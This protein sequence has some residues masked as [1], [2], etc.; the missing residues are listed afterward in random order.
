MSAFPKPSGPDVHPVNPRHPV[1]RAVAAGALAAALGLAA[2]TPAPAPDGTPS[3]SS[4]VPTSTA[5]AGSA[6][7]CPAL[8]ATVPS[9]SPRGGTI[10]PSA[11]DAPALVRSDGGTSAVADADISR[12]GGSPAAS[13]PAAGAASGAAVE[14]TGGSRLSLQRST[15]ASSGNGTGGVSSSGT[16]SLVELTDVTVSTDG[17]SAAG[18]AAGDGGAVTGTNLTVSTSQ[19]GANALAAVGAGAQISLNRS[20]ASATGNLSA[21]VYSAGDVSVCGLAGTSRSSEAALVEGANTLTS[22]RSTLEGGTNGAR[23]YQGDSGGPAGGSLAVSGGSLTGRTGDAVLI[24][25]VPATVTLSDGAGLS[26]GSGRLV[27]VTA[28]GS[29]TVNVTGTQLRGN[30]TAE[31]GSGLDLSLASNSSVSGT[32]TNVS[33]TLD[34]TSTVS[35]ESDSTAASVAGAEVSGNEILN[36]AGNGHSLTYDASA[37][38]SS[39]LNGG[40]Y[41]LAQGGTLSPA[42]P[43]DG[44]P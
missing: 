26:A 13:A 21:A 14:V 19:D 5:G 15:V 39:Y 22:T 33:V 37:P 40:T 29:G 6:A 42:G 27:N 43:G 30:L 8:A 16:G 32:L 44:V 36:I 38:E 7:D 18:V 17:P 11:G 23:L 1:R 24:E 12:S 35:L 28:G 10:T 2:C 31:P 3:E 9:A 4:P 20:P 34:T 25:G 41:N